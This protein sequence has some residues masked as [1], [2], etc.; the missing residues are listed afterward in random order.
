MI[1]DD[2][3]DAEMPSMNGLGADDRQD[4][5]DPSHLT[6]NVV[7]ARITGNIIGSIYRIPK[8]GKEGSFV[9]SVHRILRSLKAWLVVLPDG[10]KLDLNA[11]PMCASRPVASL[12]L[13]FNQVNYSL[14]RSYRLPTD[15]N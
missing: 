2:D 10:L 1:Q 13:H 6:A 8:G 4:F 15:F 12:H 14:T 7:L 3:I 9:K 11:S 5:A